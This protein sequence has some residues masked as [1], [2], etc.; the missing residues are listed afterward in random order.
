MC[1]ET[2]LF[3]SLM[4]SESEA[5]NHKFKL[6]NVTQNM[7][8][9]SNLLVPTEGKSP[10]PN[11]ILLVVTEYQ[12]RQRVISVSDPDPDLPNPDPWA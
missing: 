7:I 6:L 2:L 1:E 10:F 8:K 9:S 12:Y 4:I 3:A 11:H 5:S